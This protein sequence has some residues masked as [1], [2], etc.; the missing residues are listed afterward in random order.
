M[1]S[2]S[3]KNHAGQHAFT[4]IELLVVIS[5]IS[6]LISI[7]LP[8]LSGARKAA[9]SMKCATQLRQN[10]LASTAYAQD[11]HGYMVQYD[12]L[13]GT[14]HWSDHLY[15]GKYIVGNKAIFLCPEQPRQSYN[16]WLTYGIQF[17]NGKLDTET[18][19]YD[20]N[21]AHKGWMLNL[22]KFV[23]PARFIVYADT[24]IAKTDA[25]FPNGMWSFM[26][27]SYLGNGVGNIYFRHQTGA[28]LY[29]GD[30]HVYTTRDTRELKKAG[31]RKCIDHDYSYLNF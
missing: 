14:K 6:L 21:G 22:Q 20:T 13:S 25:S 19:I 26:P 1:K 5:I 28:N 15:N 27:F 10:G 24:I 9:R 3:I 23:K 30:G 8:A 17:D 16:S 31:I 7:L 4:L 18:K 2:T 11:N 12:T 29:F